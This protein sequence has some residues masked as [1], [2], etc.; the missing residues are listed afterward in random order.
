[1]REAGMQPL[2][3]HVVHDEDAILPETGARAIREIRAGMGTVDAVFFTSDM[4]AV[5]A[6]LA[7]RDLGIAVPAEMGIAGFHDLE[8]GRVVSPTLTTVH[9]PALEMGRKAG[10]MI[11]AR[12]SGSA[13]AARREELVF[14]IIERESTKRPI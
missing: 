5:G 2:P 4:F 3:V 8:I 9:V 7:C 6:V 13:S 10:E 11:L 1:M 12:L 14:S